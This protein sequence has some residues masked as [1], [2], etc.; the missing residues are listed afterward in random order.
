MIVRIGGWGSRVADAKLAYNVS[1]LGAYD[2]PN[3]AF[4]CISWT[5]ILAVKAEIASLYLESLRSETGTNF[6]LDSLDIHF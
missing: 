1:S 5:L 4:T 2:S 6:N 3:W